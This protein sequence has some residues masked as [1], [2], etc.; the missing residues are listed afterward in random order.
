M[1]ILLTNDDG[2]RSEG[3]DA[4]YQVLSALP[5]VTVTVIAPELNC[6]GA[7]NSLTLS[8]PVSVDKAPNGFIFING[9]PTDCVHIALTGLLER[10]PDLVVAG[11]NDGPNMGEDTLYSGTVAAAMEGYL[12]DVPSFAFSLSEKNWQGLDTAVLIA[13]LLVAKYI[14]SPLIPIA[15]L[16]VNIP[17]SV[18]MPPIIQSTKLGRRHRSQ[19]VICQKD[20]RGRTI[21]WI[22]EAGGAD[23]SIEGTDFYA[24]ANGQVSVSCLHIDLSN[25]FR[26]Q[27][28]S[29][30]LR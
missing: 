22:G 17:A 9:T 16:N 24:V 25:H 3:L 10:K 4:M 23:E 6:S 7:S 14:S 18:S 2:Y 28:I 12:F 13:K 26:N 19:G 20:P 27:E 8:R 30:W 29:S 11:M 5:D 21:Y 15:L 1:H